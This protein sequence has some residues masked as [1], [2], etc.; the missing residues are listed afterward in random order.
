MSDLTSRLAQLSPEQRALL[1]ERM[2]A[3]RTPELPAQAIAIVGMAC[4]LPGGVR[5]PAAFWDLLSG[6]VDAVTAVPADRWNA[7]A[8]FDADADAPG[9]S[10]MRT[11]AFIDGVADFDA[12][13]FGISPFEARQMDPQQRLF[14]EVAMDALDSA[15]YTR[16]QLAGSM[17][18]VFVGVHS[19]SS[20]YYAM[21]VAGLEALDTYSSTGTAHSVLANRLS[22]FLDLRGP[23]MA[24]DTACSSSLVALHQACVSLRIGESSLAVAGGLNLMLSPDFAVALSKLRVLSPGGRC[25][26]F[27]LA[28]D[29]IARGEGCGAIVLKRAADA[30]RDGDPILALIRGTAVN[31]DGAT[32]GL[33]APSTPSQIAVIRAALPLMVHRV[34]RVTRWCWAR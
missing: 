10:I 6:G 25:R 4:R 20:E 26:T 16:A 31:Q 24:I 1:L 2:A 19:H 11:G 12:G 22:Y 33:T 8:Y 21:Q 14:L 17:C 18:G 23:S 13:F 32:N 9:R 15:G 27:D 7:D 3:A 30:V 5:S 28:A 29:G 34:S